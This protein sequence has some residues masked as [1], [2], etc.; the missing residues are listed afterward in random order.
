MTTKRTSRSLSQFHT[1]V[2]G[3]SLALLGLVP[4]A[5]AQTAIGA[6]SAPAAQDRQDRQDRADVPRRDRLSALASRLRVGRDALAEL[7][8]GDLVAEI[9]EVLAGLHRRRQGASDAA[10][11]R[12]QGMDRLP[13]GLPGAPDRVTDRVQ[14]GEGESEY[15]SL[16]RRLAVARR[17][18][19]ATMAAGDEESAGVL[20]HAVKNLQLRANDAPLEEI[21][22]STQG[23]DP[24]R[25]LGAL[26]RAARHHAA[27]GRHEDARAT[28]GLVEYYPRRWGWD[29]VEE[30]QEDEVVE[31][32]FEDETSGEQARGLDDLGRRMEILRIARH[33]LLEGGHAESAALVERGLHLGELQLEGNTGE[34]FARLAAEF[35]PEA[36]LREV[37]RA[38]GLYRE[39]NAPDRAELCAALARFYA[40]RW[41]IEDGRWILGGERAQGEAGNDAGAA[42]REHSGAA[43]REHSGAAGREHAEALRREAQRIKREAEAL[44]R[45]GDALRERSEADK[46]ESDR[47]TREREALERAVAEFNAARRGEAREEA[48]E[49]QDRELQ[50]QFEDR[51]ARAKIL[52]LA[53][54]AWES[55]DEG[56][57]AQVMRRIVRLAELQ[58]KEAPPEAIAEVVRGLSQ[59]DVID[60]VARA[61]ERYAKRGDEKAARIC[62]VL[63]RFY[64]EREEAREAARREA[65]ER[66]ARERAKAGASR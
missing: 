63:H 3:A 20:E 2:C 59:Q 39:W 15:E 26:R 58:L 44:R 53:A 62:G 56:E 65:E 6:R 10:P 36:L 48:R 30:V 49:S 22:A 31:E 33:G 13:P 8:R 51:A 16:E 28:R 46:A 52:R 32:V 25:L 50:A 40:E 55:D 29:S 23:F 17:A 61:A 19:R 42:R 34:E 54:R 21:N 11:R 24:E 1:A 57:H 14:G 12:A 66:A 41:R 18:L 5:T 38:A 35:E 27:A 7:G 9:D 60:S 64:V 37:R 47:L 45:E 43:I 4:T